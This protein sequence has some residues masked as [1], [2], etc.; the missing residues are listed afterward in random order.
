[1]VEEEGFAVWSFVDAAQLID[2]RT[3]SACARC[4]SIAD[5]AVLASKRETVGWRSCLYRRDQLLG[6]GPPSVRHSQEGDSRLS[7][8][9]QTER[10]RDTQGVYSCPCIQ[11][12]AR[13]GKGGNSYIR[14]SLRRDCQ[15]RNSAAGKVW[16]ESL[17]R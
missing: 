3:N 9:A 12:C 8:E 14:L 11:I 4:F 6:A 7:A 16:R 10:Q 1:M 5:V 17:V 13:P 2:H 15:R